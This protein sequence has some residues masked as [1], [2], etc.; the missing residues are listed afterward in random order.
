MWTNFHIFSLLISEKICGKAGIR[1]TTSPQICCHTTLWKVNGQLYSFTAQLIRFKVMKKI[2]DYGKLSRGCY[3]FVFFSTQI[4]L[5][6][7]FKMSAFGQTHVL[8][9]V[10]HWL[11]DASMCVVQCCA[12]MFIFITERNEYC[13]KQNIAI[14]S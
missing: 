2:F 8:S 14:M 9:S 7:E 1:T 13:S 5:R 6:H 12:K 11:V 10:W 3:S 4:N